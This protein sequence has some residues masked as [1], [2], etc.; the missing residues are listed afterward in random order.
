M[1]AS[2][3]E[4]QPNP[5]GGSN[6]I[7]WWLW[8]QIL[9]L[10][11]PL[12]A[13][14]WLKALEQS[15]HLKLSGPYF[16]VLGIATWLIYLIDRTIDAEHSTFG[17]SL[18]VRH[19]FCHRYRRWI[20]CLWVPSL[21]LALAWLA[22]TRLPVGLLEHGSAVAMLAGLYLALF[23]ARPGSW[24]YRVLIVFSMLVAFTLAQDLPGDFFSFW[25]LSATLGVVF[26]L[27]LL[28]NRG[29]RDAALPRVFKEPL[30]ALLFTLG[31]TAG[32]HLWTPPEHGLLCRD[33]LFLW[34]LFALN[35]QLIA[36]AESWHG[37]VA[38]SPISFHPAGWAA[39]LILLCEFAAGTSE[40]SEAFATNIQV[41]A[42]LLVFLA[43]RMT[44]MRLELFHTLADLAL[45]LPLAWSLWIAQ[46]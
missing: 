15:H 25:R 41:A 29:P 8:P 35:L 1:L 10:D 46:R 18:G 16:W 23:A 38:S 24:Q 9:S 45:L 36:T 31:C 3:P 14:G 34:G 44:R 43:M 20:W 33:G 2:T 7:P 21:A 40:R 27:I 19:A 22:L 6:S 12:V 4:D 11:A 28:W 42:V 39:V 32:V 13:V 17:G 26:V 37:S 30:A 5:P